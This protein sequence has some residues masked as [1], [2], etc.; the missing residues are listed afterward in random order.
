MRICF[1]RHLQCLSAVLVIALALGGNLPVHAQALTGTVNDPQG[2]PLI[3]RI[4]A[5]NP[6]TRA[7]ATGFTDAQGGF[8]LECP[9]GELQVWVTCGPEWSIVEYTAVVGDHRTVVLERIVNMS[10]RNYYGVDLHM[11][12]TASDGAQ[13][14]A[15]M[16]WAARA[17]G[18]HA[19]ALTDHNTQDGLPEWLAQADDGFL[20]L[21][22]EEVTTRLGHF[23]AINTTRPISSDVQGGAEDIQRIFREIREDGGFSAIAHPAVPGM[24]YQHPEIIDYDAVEILNGSL[25]PYGGLFNVLQ[26]RLMWHQMLS[27]G[28]EVPAIGTSDCHESK[29]AIARNAVEDPEAFTERERRLGV[30]MR[31]FSF[32]DVLLPWALKG[33]HVGAYR[34]YVN[35]PQLTPADIQEAVV[36]GRSFVTNGPLIDARLADTLPGSTITLDQQQTVTLQSE[37]FANRP[38]ERLEVL[39]N[40]EAVIT[41]TE[42]GQTIGDIA[43][44]VS[45]GDWVAVELYGPWPEFATTNAWYIR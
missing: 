40:G 45:A 2:L 36:A 25:P 24:H 28:R 8:V 33:S 10:A 11:H 14:P 5:F 12:S 6:E 42:P 34:T 21:T 17:E 9:P 43:V 18:L 31:L 44:P 32:E 35:I 27:E 3:A 41:I 37:L 29:N 13:T 23:L 22:G 4:S 7:S 19:A 26:A 1:T 20:P 39:V 15:R 16:A 30:I 38:L